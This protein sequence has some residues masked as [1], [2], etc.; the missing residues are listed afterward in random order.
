M[1]AIATLLAL[2]IFGIVLIIG[3]EA[4]IRTRQ[5]GLAFLHSTGEF[6]REAS[7][8]IAVLGFLDQNQLAT[9]VKIGLAA[10]TFLLGMACELGLRKA[11]DT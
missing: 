3:L 9:A 2:T 11:K 1:G 8:L 10:A 4:S 7:V 6:F 5:A